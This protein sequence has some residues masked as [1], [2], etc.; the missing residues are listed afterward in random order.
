MQA[1]PPPVGR[2]RPRSEDAPRRPGGQPPQ[3]PLPRRPGGA[4]E[5][6]GE[7]EGEEEEEQ[8]EQE[9][10]DRKRRTKR[11]LILKIM[12]LPID[13]PRRLLC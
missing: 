5:E 1:A 8:E 13:R 10:E 12:Q 3:L 4:E 6:E 11:N 9:E 2:G 7:E